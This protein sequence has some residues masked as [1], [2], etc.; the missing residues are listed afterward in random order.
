[1]R[2]ST[3][4]PKSERNGFVRFVLLFTLLIALGDPAEA[5]AGARIADD[6][7]G[8]HEVRFQSGDVPL[9]G[10]VLVPDR[11]RY[12]P[13]PA[14]A[15]VHG[16]GPGPRDQLRREAEAF[17]RRGI[18]TLIYDKRNEGY[19]ESG[20]GERSYGLLADDAL[21]AVHALQRHPAVDPNAVGLWGL[22]EDGW[23]V[24]LAANRSNDVAFVV[25]VGAS[26]VPPAR[27]V[28]WYLENELRHQGVSGSMVEA[29]SR[30]GIRVQAG[31]GGMAEANH[32]PVAPLGRLRQPALALWGEKDRAV[33]PAESARIFEDALRNGPNKS[34]TI[35]FFPNAQHGLESS[36]DG[37]ARGDTLADGYPET[38]ASWIEEVARGEAPPSSVGVPPPQRRLSRPLE[39]LSWWE[40]GWMQ[41]SSITFPLL[42]FGSY[43]AVA[44]GARLVRSTR[45]RPRESV[46]TTRPYA[47]RW[48]WC[49]AFGGIAAVLGSVC[50]F[51]FL[52]AT[53]GSVVGPV[54]AGR[55][56]PWLILQALSVATCACVLML[57]ASWGRA[58]KPLGAVRV[59]RLG[60]VLAGGMVFAAWAVYWGLLLP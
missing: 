60:A 51:G 48:A 58:P 5:K 31:T 16:S 12:G 54:V 24:P 8:E 28:A 19:S 57:A 22:S 13:L 15:L 1:M 9:A 49:V 3:R 45:G 25:L 23:V 20:L 35:R 50:Y 46:E 27:Q 59:A 2:D 52:V 37:F 36:P 47:R 6:G 7:F 41:L 14:V 17:A 55:P 53:A 26:G 11:A 42:A 10:T 40:S 56:I 43:P 30:T 33:P 38:V 4:S 21:S 34:H 44:L 18:V 29:V 32:D 39:P